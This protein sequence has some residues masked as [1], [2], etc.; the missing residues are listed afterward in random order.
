[1]SASEL[2]ETHLSAPFSSTF[3]RSSSTSTIVPDS[4]ATSTAAQSIENQPNT[5]SDPKGIGKSRSLLKLLSPSGLPVAT[6]AASGAIANAPAQPLKPGILVVTIHEGQGFSLTKEDEDRFL[7]RDSNGYAP[8]HTKP[9]SIS[10]A[11][12]SLPTGSSY[13]RPKTSGGAINSVPTVHGRYSS[14]YLPY[15]IID[16]DKQQV[17]VNGV[18]GSPENPLWAGPSTQYKFDVSR[19]TDV[20]ISVYI[21]NPN[22]PPNAGRSA[23]IWIGSAR[24]RPSF[25]QR[26]PGTDDKSKQSK[27][28]MERSGVQSGVEWSNIHWTNPRDPADI[29]HRG[30]ISVGV[31]F[32]ENLTQSLKIDDFEL[33]KVVGKGSFGKVMQVMLVSLL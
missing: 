33:L 11:Q 6:L 31:D 10:L 1:M 8:G 30:A 19:V 21:R 26:Q 17:F 13:G 4:D 20:G 14:K 27:P 28:G 9:N 15:A 25:E 18:S 3:N 5:P 29:Q 32:V 22:A 12:G 2:K 23:D 16:F 24:I 7:N